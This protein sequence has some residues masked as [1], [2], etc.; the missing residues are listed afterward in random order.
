MRKIIAIASLALVA[1]SG[2][3]SAED[4]G[5]SIKP[6]TYVWKADMHHCSKLIIGEDGIHQYQSDELCD[7]TVNYTAVNVFVID[8]TIRIDRAIVELS[9]VQDDLIEGQWK[10]FDYNTLASF[11]RQ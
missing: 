4:L 3:V 5:Q 2:A 10:L 7:G 6:G 8:D 9:N 11:K 1:L